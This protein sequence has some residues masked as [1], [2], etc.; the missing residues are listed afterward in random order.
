LT[1]N[2]G[3]LF[4]AELASRSPTSLSGDEFT[5]SLDLANDQRL[6]YSVFTYGFDKFL[7]LVRSKSL[8]GLQRAGHD[9]RKRDP[10]D[11]FPRFYRVSRFAGTDQ[12]A[13]TFA[14][15]NLCHRK[16]EAN[17]RGGRKQRRRNRRSAEPKGTAALLRAFAN[18]K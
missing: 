12:R 11:A 8:S 2:D 4:Q 10:F 15:N 18:F 9:L 1:Y 13:K 14:E 17:G 6:D 7:K 16:F 5:F 3:C